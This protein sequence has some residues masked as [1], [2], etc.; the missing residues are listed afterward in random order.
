VLA[1]SRILNDEEILIVANAN[2]AQGVS[3]E[4]ILDANL[5][6]PNAQLQVLYSNKPGA[7]GPSAVR[8]TGLV[9]VHEVD[10]STGNGPLN[11]IRVTLQ[12]YEVQILGK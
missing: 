10:G 11:V 1:F 9:T 6:P 5:N 2:G 7:T 3:L 4:V 8:Q 12:P